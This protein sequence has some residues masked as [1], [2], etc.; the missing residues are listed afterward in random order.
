MP[1]HET[2][3]W[4]VKNPVDERSRSINATFMQRLH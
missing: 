4:T 3:K 1:F 2:K